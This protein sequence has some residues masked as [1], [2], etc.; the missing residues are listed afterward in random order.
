MHASERNAR[1]WVSILLWHVV[2]DDSTQ[3]GCTISPW[4]YLSLSAARERCSLSVWHWTYNSRPASLSHSAFYSRLSNAKYAEYICWVSKIDTV[5]ETHFTLSALLCLSRFLLSKSTARFHFC[6][7][8]FFLHFLF[9][10][11]LPVSF[12]LIVL[13]FIYF[14]FL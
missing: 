2:A 4:G 13:V 14:C 12:I 10:F 6:N 3:L 9:L 7:Y 1:D 5:E 8:S 11:L